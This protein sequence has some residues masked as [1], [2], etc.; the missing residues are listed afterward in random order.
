MRHDTVVWRAQRPEAFSIQL[1]DKGANRRKDQL[2]DRMHYALLKGLTSLT[3]RPRQLLLVSTVRMT[4]LVK[5]CWRTRRSECQLLTSHRSPDCM[6]RACAGCGRAG[7]SVHAGAG[8][9]CEALRILKDAG[10]IPRS[11]EQQLNGWL[12]PPKPG[13]GLPEDKSGS[14]GAVRVR[15]NTRDVSRRRPGLD[16]AAR[17]RPQ[18]RDTG[19]SCWWRR[20]QVNGGQYQQSPGVATSAAA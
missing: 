4:N 6:T 11:D 14:F 9:R 7:H 15:S 19:R 8:P 16:G 18:W 20:R 5:A 10:A 1:L 17:G 3:A 13:P 12:P 2:R